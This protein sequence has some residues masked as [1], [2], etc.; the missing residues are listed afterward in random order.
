MATTD[1]ITLRIAPASIS[2]QV[3][4][5]A[6]GDFGYTI[7]FVVNDADGDA[8]NISTYTVAVNISMTTGGTFAGLRLTNV[9]GTDEPILAGAS[10][11]G[12]FWRVPLGAEFV[13]IVCGA[14]QTSAARTFYIRGIA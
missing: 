3:I 14:G 8:Q 5:V 9:D 1:T 4:T 6:T 10:T 2:R 11:G 12:F 13:K 7:P